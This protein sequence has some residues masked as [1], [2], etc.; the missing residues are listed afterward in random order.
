MMDIPATILKAANVTH[1]TTYEGRAV[2][3]LQGKALQP[4]LE[5]TKD[6]VRNPSD[7]LG[8]ELFGNRAIREDNWKLLWL[9]K[10]YGTGDWQLYDLKADPGEIKDLASELPQ[11]RDR[12]IDHWRTYTEKNNVILPDR[13]PIC[14]DATQAAPANP[15]H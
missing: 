6:S 14:R 3:P 5:N 4:I 12:L 15:E 10:P 7:W 1:P 8:W 11:V 2:A 9:C 13:S